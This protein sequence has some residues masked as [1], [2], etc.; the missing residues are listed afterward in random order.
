MM[1][2]LNGHWERIFNRTRMTRECFVRF[3]GIL[4][5]IG[6]L[7]PSRSVSVEEQLMIFLFVVGHEASNRNS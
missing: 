3:S 5:G 7:L 4:E 6:R 2:F 1:E